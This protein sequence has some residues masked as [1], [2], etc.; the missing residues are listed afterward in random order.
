MS[1]LKIEK[2]ANQAIDIRL[3]NYQ[4]IVRNGF[5]CTGLCYGKMWT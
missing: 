3:G 5:V 4:W 1:E 2:E